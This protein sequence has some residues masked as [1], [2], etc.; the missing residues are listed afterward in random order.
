MFLPAVP[1]SPSLLSTPLSSA[2]SSTSEVNV[3]LSAD[4]SLPLQMR[5]S[6]ELLEQQAMAQ[7]V[8]HQQAA[9]EEE[10][11]DPLLP[12]MWVWGGGKVEAGGSGGAEFGLEGRDE[13]VYEGV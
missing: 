12:A 8:A 3:S 7:T 4:Q 1:C 10:G 5:L 2:P 11:Y 13:I 6:L 9:G